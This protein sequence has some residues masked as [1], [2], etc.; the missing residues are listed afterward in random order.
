MQRL[1]MR[2]VLV[3]H[4]T[5]RMPAICSDTSVPQTRIHGAEARTYVQCFENVRGK[6]AA[7][8]TR[9]PLSLCHRASLAAEIRS[10]LLVRIESPNHS[11]E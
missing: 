9:I 1:S 6:S 8:R 11:A 3:P 5:Q 4:V 10:H 2:H 7:R